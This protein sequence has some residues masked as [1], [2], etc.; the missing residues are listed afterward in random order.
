MKGLKALASGWGLY[1]L[2]EKLGITIEDTTTTIFTLLFLFGC[3]AALY[4]IL[5]SFL[6]IFRKTK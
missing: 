6:S 2:L 3:F 5:R 4:S 1:N